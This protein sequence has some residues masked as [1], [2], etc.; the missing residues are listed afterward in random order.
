VG[1]GYALSDAAAWPTSWTRLCRH[2]S[3]F[4]SSR[5]IP[6]AEVLNDVDFTQVCVAFGSARAT[7]EV[8]ND[9]AGGRH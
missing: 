3:T 8:G 2:A 9:A 7:E 4:A 6:Q 1:G 5:G